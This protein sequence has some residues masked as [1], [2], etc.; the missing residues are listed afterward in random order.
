MHVAAWLVGL[1]CAVG[2]ALTPVDRVMAARQQA[3]AALES[4]RGLDASR[5]DATHATHAGHLDAIMTAA[6]RRHLLARTGFGVPPAEFQALDGLSRQQG[7]DKIIAGLNTE[8]TLAMPE[9]T[10]HS[11]PHY[12]AKSDMERP[13][14]VQFDQR[15]DAELASLRNWWVAEMLGGSSAATERLVLMWHDLMPSSYRAINRGS[16]ALARQNALF[17][18][19]HQG[20]WE[21]LLKEML[22][23]AALLQYLD[24]TRNKKNAPNENLARELLELFTLGVGNYSERD[25]REAA[26][27]LTGH[28]THPIA[29]LAFRLNTGQHDRTDKTILGQTGP[30]KA[31]ALVDI[32]LQQP[33]AARHLARHYWHALI[34]DATPD[35]AA[36][37]AIANPFRQSG[38]DLGVLYRT[39]LESESFWANE[40]RAGLVK[41][42]VDIITGLARTL[43]YPKQASMRLASLQG[44]LGLAF[45]EPPN[46]AGWDEGDAW[47]TP[48]RLISRLDAAAELSRGD[49][50]V[51]APA[52]NESMDMTNE[53]M[54]MTMASM[55]EDRA[56]PSS[57]AGARLQIRIASE[58]Y[59]GQAAIVV[60]TLVNDSPTWTSEVVPLSGGFDTE[61]LGRRAAR[62]DLPWQRLDLELPATV[63]ETAEAVR[64]GFINDAAGAGGD[65]NVFVDS[66]RIG[67]RSAS[68][69]RGTQ[70]SGCVQ[71]DEPGN[72]YC[73]GAVTVPLPPVNAQ[74][75]QPDAR[76]S[77]IRLRWLN[78]NEANGRVNANMVLENVHLPG[79]SAELLQFRVV[80]KSGADAE[81]HMDSMD[82]RPV[83]IEHWPD[84]VWRDPHNP[85][86]ASLVVPLHPAARRDNACFNESF[87]PATREWLDLLADEVPALVRSLR[88]SRVAE[89]K[90]AAFSELLSRMDAVAAPGQRRPIKIDSAFAPTAPPIETPSSVTPAIADLDE[91]VSVLEPEGIDVPLLLWPG[92][93]IDPPHFSGTPAEQLAAVLAHPAFQLR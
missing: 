57:E 37:D 11:L 42:P 72:L 65:R 36:L 49:N 71:N 4:D 69:A 18:R 46:V 16:L 89:Q 2:L 67:Q 78:H 61:K 52:S 43:E 6:D 83:C 24:N 51:L 22:R 40:H 29:E 3:P 64:I 73:N 76:A 8:P 55:D 15:R 87:Y 13:Q 82:C 41:S 93:D 68:A 60:W 91:L 23:D 88:G 90:P 45:F 39:V 32:V 21:A 75:D 59:Q 79:M 53:S 25:V 28:A 63:A 33:A 1:V 62:T 80:D 26:R 34:S 66:L 44:A 50:T 30:F 10:R 5:L 48:S 12:H 17:R 86:I 92:I 19:S 70:V 85:A 20:S 74:V 58:A 47:I 14:R 81:L 31:D 27:A 35:D 7:I 84:C 77:A 56:N 9:W 54:D 38:H